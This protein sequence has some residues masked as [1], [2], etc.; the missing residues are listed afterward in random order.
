V[1]KWKA[2]SLEAVE[3]HNKAVLFLIKVKIFRNDNKKKF[4]DILLIRIIVYNI[5]KFNSV[6]KLEKKKAKH[7]TNK[8]KIE[9]IKMKPEFGHPI[10]PI[11]LPK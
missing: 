3:G 2:E 1:A 4:Y 7:M 11:D 8:Y 6:A 10:W 9:K 5:T